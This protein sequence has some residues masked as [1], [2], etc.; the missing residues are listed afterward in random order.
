MRGRDDLDISTA[1]ANEQS[2]GITEG[3][4]IVAN[5]P[6]AAQSVFRHGPHAGGKVSGELENYDRE[7]N[8]SVTNERVAAGKAG[9]EISA[10]QIPDKNN[11]QSSEYG[12]YLA[13]NG[14]K[15][16]EGQNGIY[17]AVDRDG[18]PYWT[19]PP[20]K[21]N[22]NSPDYGNFLA[23]NGA[24]LVNNNGTFYAID[25]K[26]GQP[27]WTTRKPREDNDAIWY[28]QTFLKL[29]NEHP[30]WSEAKLHGEMTRIVLEANWADQFNKMSTEIDSSLL[31]VQKLL[32]EK[33]GPQLLAFGAS[34]FN[35]DR[36]TNTDYYAALYNQI[37]ANHGELNKNQIYALME[38]RIKQAY[39]LAPDNDAF[40]DA[41]LTDEDKANGYELE[42]NENGVKWRICGTRI[43]P[44]DLAKYL[45]QQEYFGRI[46]EVLAS[47]TA[48]IGIP[49]VNIGA[50]IFPSVVKP[51]SEFLAK[52]ELLSNVLKG[53]RQTPE[54][55]DGINII[56]GK[57][58]GK[59]VIDDFIK[60]RTQSIYNPNAK[61][62]TL[63]KYTKIMENG[64]EKAGPDS[65]II[66]AGNN[67]AYFDLGSEWITIQK[68]Y[69]LTD[70]EMFEYFNIPALDDAVWSGKTIRFSH[71]PNIYP[72]KSYLAQEWDYLKRIPNITLRKEGDVWIA[73]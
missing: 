3:Q 7:S 58:G 20:D 21:E 54:I 70:G 53:L 57:V 12:D 59:I 66:K 5:I 30:D 28:N 51:F 9:Q 61:S 50:D 55:M 39:R 4:V 49:E 34:G 10:S 35:I 73:E 65:Y 45:R 22:L 40:V 14:A 38:E 16:V 15:I 6:A 24:Y 8:G 64:V 19:V 52:S 32:V 27:Y 68:R 44:D 11:R 71:D 17:Y 43:H 48:Y 26:D 36:Y 56:N 25:P 62:M 69:N 1:Y 67:S 18:Q 2:G 42:T 41:E 31:E 33:Y 13:A 46:A 72:A 63:G 60:I 37:A 29:Q 47:K 23:Q